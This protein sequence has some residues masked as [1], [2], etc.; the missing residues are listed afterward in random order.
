V[1]SRCAGRTALLRGAEK[2]YQWRPC[3]LYRLKPH[4]CGGSIIGK[5]AAHVTKLASHSSSMRNAHRKVL[6]V[7]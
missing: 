2:R 6:R 5:H 3:Y 1:I 4:A 7:K